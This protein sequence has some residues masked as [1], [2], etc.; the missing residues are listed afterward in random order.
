MLWPI[1]ERRGGI[2]S[3][4]SSRGI[5]ENPMWLDAT[6]DAVGKPRG[7]SSGTTVALRRGHRQCCGLGRATLDA[8]SGPGLPAAAVALTIPEPGPPRGLM[9]PMLAGSREGVDVLARS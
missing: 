8:E 3:L 4:F 9:V 5:L 2:E 6:I 7:V 1:L